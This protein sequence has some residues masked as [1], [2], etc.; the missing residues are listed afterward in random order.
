MLKTRDIT[1]KDI[2]LATFVDVALDSAFQLHLT[3]FIHPSYEMG[4]RAGTM[5][6]DRIE[7]N[8]TGEPVYV[9]MVPT[10]VIQHSTRPQQRLQE[11]RPLG[12]KKNPRGKPMLL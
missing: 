10:L 1:P 2:A 5:L 9:Q 8:L 7:S 3:A 11:Y 6:I 12:G 4:A